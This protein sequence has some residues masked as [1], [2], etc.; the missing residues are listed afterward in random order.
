MLEGITLKQISDWLAISPVGLGSLSLSIK[1]ISTDSRTLQSSS[2]FV[3]IRGE[4]F[5]GHDYIGEAINRGAS[6]IL[7]ERLPQNASQTNCLFFKVSSSLLAFSEVAKQL[8]NQFSGKVIAITGSAGKSSTKDM[9]GL[10]LGPHHLVS[11]KSFNNLLGV[12]KTICLLNEKTENLVLEMGMNA[13]GEIAQ[14]CEVFNPQGGAITNIGDAHIGKLGGREGIYQAK[15]EL[16]DHIGKI[17]GPLGVALNQDDPW[18]MRAAAEALGS[19]I[20]RITFSALD[21][22]ADIF[23][24]QR[25]V[26]P[27]T[28]NLLFHLDVSGKTMKVSLP[29]FGVHQALNTAAAVAIAKLMGISDSQI[30]QRLPLLVPSESRGVIREMSQGV[31]LIDESYNSNPSALLSALES[32]F[33]MAPLRR[34][35]L[36]I[37]EMRELEE[38]SNKLHREVGEKLSQHLEDLSQNSVI[39]GVGAHTRPL[40][41]AIPQTSKVVKAYF[42]SVEELNHSWE[43]FLQPQDLVML[44]GSRGVGLEKALPI[45]EQLTSK[46]EKK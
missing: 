31:T 7:C 32:V 45:L 38:F 44:K 46:E 3:A 23:V 37:G 18:V 34:K 10:L 40:L 1:D 25:E 16:F 19:E 6:A 28:G 35:L 24:S 12:S 8:R 4:H 5:D 42:D 17:G 11:P 30:E 26:C 9:A 15:K 33:L 27:K 20:R 43:K 2:L 29:H 21:S 36:V 22:K 13:K 39:I 41:D 14:M